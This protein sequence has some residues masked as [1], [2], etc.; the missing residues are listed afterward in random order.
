MLARYNGLVDIWRLGM[1]EG[2]IPE[3]DDPQIGDVGIV[4]VPTPNGIEPIG[5]IF[6][7]KRWLMLSERGVISASVN[8][9]MHWRV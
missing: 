6:A 4:E 3:C 7:G 2:G 8:A 1:I 5:A 9:V